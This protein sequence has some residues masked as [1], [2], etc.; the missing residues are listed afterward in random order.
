VEDIDLGYRLRSGGGRILLAK[1]VQVKHL[2]TWSLRSLVTS[3]YRDRGL[4]WA[5][6]LIRNRRKGGRELNLSLRSRISVIVTCL[7][8]VFLA[9]S[10]LRPVFLAV[11]ATTGLSLLILNLDFYG[12]L[13]RERGLLFAMRSVPL[14][15]L[16]YAIGAA[17]FLWSSVSVILRSRATGAEA[18][19][20]SRIA[21]N[22]DADVSR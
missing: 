12:F 8:G 14:H 15:T 9:L 2:K 4:P 22:V 21:D 13:G 17:A 10:V 18:P 6:L 11:A 16:H 3:E 7:T 20:A 5:E 1:Q 19:A